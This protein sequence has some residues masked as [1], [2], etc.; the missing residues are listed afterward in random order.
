MQN[1]LLRRGWVWILLV[2]LMAGSTSQASDAYTENEES[3][4][5]FR[6]F[7]RTARDTPEEQLTYADGLQSH[8]RLKKADR[9]YRAL[10]DQWPAS[11]EAA[12]AQHKHADLLRRR[13]KHQQAFDQLQTLIDTYPGRF[14]YDDVLQSQ[15]DIAV[16]VMNLKHGKLWILPG[17][18]A[19]ERALD[20]LARVVK[21]GP[22]SKHAAEAQYLQGSIREQVKE[23]ELAVVDYT[24]TMLR[25]P[26]SSFAEKAAF[27]R[28]RCL[29][30]LS[31]ESPNDT[32]SAQ[33]AWH[34]LTLFN[35]TYPKSEYR[36]RADQYSKQMYNRL[37]RG[38]YDIAVFYDTKAQKY[39]AAL[40]AYE[41]FVRRFP[42]SQ[43]TQKANQ[44]IQALK[45]R[46]GE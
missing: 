15:F 13:G 17:F 46:A 38:A 31:N 16:K 11:P 22:R 33:E 34:A 18:E 4:R 25:Y 44:R 7:L 41:S 32:D 8:G 29:V 20:M 9:Q 30:R 23:I 26:E 2:I 3:Q 36:Q 39:E 27:G 14:D 21:N 37:A 42:S 43:W 24:E 45:Q 28:A 12:V 19:P 35:T 6:I 40:F 5:T 1:H 10:I